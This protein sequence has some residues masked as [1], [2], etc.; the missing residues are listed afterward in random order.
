MLKRTWCCDI[1]K[2]NKSKMWRFALTLSRPR[3]QFTHMLSDRIAYLQAAP[4]GRY[5]NRNDDPTLIP[6]TSICRHES[7][8][9]K[10]SL[11]AQWR[12][13]TRQHQGSSYPLIELWKKKLKKQLSKRKLSAQ[14]VCWLTVALSLC[15]RGQERP[16]LLQPAEKP[17]VEGWPSF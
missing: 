6:I 16:R 11:F 14:C 5:E 4:I 17:E 10:A 7:G 1:I 15:C 8:A 13:R 3:W 2:P 12:K 9:L